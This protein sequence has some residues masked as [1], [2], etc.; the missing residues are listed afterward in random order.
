[1]LPFWSNYLPYL[2]ISSVTTEW[3]QGILW[4]SKPCK[5]YMET[6]HSACQHSAADFPKGHPRMKTMARQQRCLTRPDTGR[7]SSRLI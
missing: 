7:V 4:F 3:L 2:V 5:V 1:M 6:I